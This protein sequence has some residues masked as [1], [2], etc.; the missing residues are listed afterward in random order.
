MSEHGLPLFYAGPDVAGL[1]VPG[2]KIVGSNEGM[3]MCA[4]PG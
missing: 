2:L 3:V 1:K 4:P